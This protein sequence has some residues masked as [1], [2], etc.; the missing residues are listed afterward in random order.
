[1]VL[2]V[3][4]NRHTPVGPDANCKDINNNSNHQ[5]MNGASVELITKTHDGSQ[6]PGLL[7]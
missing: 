5:H 2:P 3:R 1:V 6:S 7:F 4:R